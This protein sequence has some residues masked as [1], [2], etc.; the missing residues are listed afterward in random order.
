MSILKFAMI[1]A[2]VGYGI[3]YVTKKREDGT[4]IIDD[5]AENVPEWFDKGKQYATQTI[6]QVTDSIKKHTP[7]NP[8][9]M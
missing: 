3:Y 6:D 9:E 1:G 5:L 8:G 2:A 4:S 7:H